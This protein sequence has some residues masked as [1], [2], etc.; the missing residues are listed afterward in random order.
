MVAMFVWRKYEKSHT[1]FC[2]FFFFLTI[3]AYVAAPN[4]LFPV[5]FDEGKTFAL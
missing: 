5:E 1:K 2:G 3:I 4:L